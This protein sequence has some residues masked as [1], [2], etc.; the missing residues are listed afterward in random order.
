MIRE[1]SSRN[2]GRGEKMKSK[3]GAAGRVLLIL[4]LVLAMIVA[5][6]PFTVSAS[7]DTT[8]LIA[9]TFDDG[10]SN[11]TVKLLDGLKERNVP[12]TFFMCGKNGSHGTEN[13]MDL[14]Y[15]MVREGHQLGNHSFTHPSIGSLSGSAVASQFGQVETR[16]FQAMGGSYTDFVRTPGGALNSTIRNNCGA[17]IILW[18][19]DTLDW[20]TRNADSVYNSIIKSSKDGS[21]VLMHDLYATSVTGAL[22]AIDT[23]KKQ[24]YEFVTVSELMR[25][26]GITPE[27]GKSYYSCY[28]DTILPAY[29]A[30]QISGVRDDSTM[31]TT[32][33]MSSADQGITFYYTLDGSYPTLGSFRYDGPFKLEKDSTFTVVGYDKYGT[34]TPMA[35]ASFKK[36]TIAKPE[37]Y[38]TSDGMIALK[39][40]STA[41]SVYYTTDGSD[42]IA[43]GQ[44]YTGPFEMEKADLR[45]VAKYAQAEPSEIAY[46]QIAG[47]KLFN[48]MDADAWYFDLVSDAVR[49]GLM[50]GGGDMNFMPNDKLS[51]AMM[52]RILYNMEGHPEVTEDQPATEFYD[53]H[54]DDWFASAVKWAYANGISQGYSDE[55]FGANDPVT[56][57][58]LVTLLYRYSD[59]Y[60]NYDVEVEGEVDLSRFADS[61]NISDYAEKAV[62]WAVSLG[63]IIGNEKG[64][65]SPRDPASRA[66]AA[67]ILMRYKALE[68]S[69]KAAVPADEPDQGT[70][71]DPDEDGDADTDGGSGDISI[72]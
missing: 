61:D 6:V 39:C 8:K 12:A 55:W 51:R 23:L 48:D 29:S 7:A 72:E 49:E 68:F 5:V 57:D 16:L 62:E 65:I 71:A 40:A 38:E 10:P 69:E 46:Y 70:D 44:L 32:V 64:E 63:L 13:H 21:I 24:G 47:G 34:R 60:K 20:K 27:T 4:V 66:A 50:V 45:A 35:T 43:N 41:A 11:N 9:F 67:V 26:K 25:R 59:K 22:R 19:V 30:P 58:Q 36:F 18:S 2:E 14:L 53:V 52:V 56:R 28:G 31:I 37:A 3:K 17:P 1:L 42:P 15:R 54:E 33:S